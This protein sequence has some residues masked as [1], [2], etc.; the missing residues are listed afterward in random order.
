VSQLLA[1]IFPPPY[2]LSDAKKFIEI[3]IQE[4]KNKNSI[5][6]VF[7][8]TN[9]SS[10][11][12]YEIHLTRYGVGVVTVYQTEYLLISKFAKIKA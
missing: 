6:K 7:N 1:P 10:Q 4:M 5:K 11:D 12:K 8:E 2:L 9:I 3:N